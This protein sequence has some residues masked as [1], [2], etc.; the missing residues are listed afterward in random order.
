MEWIESQGGPLI[1]L[2][3][4]LLAFWEGTDAP[5]SGRV[6]RADSRASGAAVATDYDRAC[7]VRRVMGAIEV[8]PGIGL[9]L[10][11]EPLPSTWFPLGDH[12]EGMIVRWRY[13]NSEEAIVQALNSVP[14]DAFAQSGLQIEVAGPLVLFDAAMPGYDIV[15]PYLTI[16]MA[17]G[18]CRVQATQY[19]PDPDT[20]LILHRFT[21][22]KSS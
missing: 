8:G 17:A 6:V 9:V 7:D 13:A 12:T 18:F 16:N 11:G 14:A 2:E 21:R 5:K 15:T 20:A 1:L 3:E 10:A 22:M 19:I 4:S